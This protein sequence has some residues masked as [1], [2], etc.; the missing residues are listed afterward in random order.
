MILRVTTLIALSILATC[1]QAEPAWKHVRLRCGASVEMPTGWSVVRAEP[2]L[3]AR[4]CGVSLSVRRS[5][6]SYDRK[7]TIEVF[8][9]AWADLCDLTGVCRDDEGTW[10]IVGRLGVK[11]EADIRDV[12]GRR[13]LR[14]VSETG[15]YGEDGTSG[16]QGMAPVPVAIVGNEH[17]AL[18]ILVGD[19]DITEDEFDRIVASLIPRGP[20]SPRHQARQ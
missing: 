13:I 4:S 9:A 5:P 1:G 16:Y 6:G 12:S 18:A 2:W 7:L 10:Q 15:W 17:E 20:E 8:R 14:G 19:H 3:V 11:N